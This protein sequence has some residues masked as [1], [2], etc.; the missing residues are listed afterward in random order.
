MVAKPQDLKNKAT[1]EEVEGTYLIRAYIGSCTGG[2][3]SDFI[4]AA[5]IIQGNKV[6][7]DTYIV[8]ATTEIA[9]GLETE[10]ISG[11]PLIEIFREAGCNIGNASCAA[12]SE[13]RRVGKEC[14]TRLAVYHWQKKQQET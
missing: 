4:A 6:K 14:R 10:T 1:V 12:R 11:V 7:L 3:L 8:P 13:E 2:K 9:R 5:E